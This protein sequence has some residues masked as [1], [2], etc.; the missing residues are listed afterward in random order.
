M[1]RR[2]PFKDVQGPLTAIHLHIHVEGGCG[3]GGNLAVHTEW[4][5]FA[6][7]AKPIHL[8]TVCIVISI[9]LQKNWESYILPCFGF[10]GMWWPFLGLM[11]RAPERRNPIC[12]RRNIDPNQP[13]AVSFREFSWGVYPNLWT[14]NTAPNHSI[15]CG[16]LKVDIQ[17]KEAMFL[18]P[19]V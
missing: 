16:N 8:L 4:T 17:K 19:P 1:F 5:C 6:F 9:L 10:V 11:D 18:N 2:K 3:R 12:K 14:K 15:A 7:R 13:L